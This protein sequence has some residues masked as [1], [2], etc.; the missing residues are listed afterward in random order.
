VVGLIAAFPKALVLAVAG[1]ALLGTIG[2][3]MGVAMKD[4]KSASRRSSPSSSPPAGWRCGAWARRSGAWWRG[5]WRSAV[6]R[7]RAA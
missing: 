4:E 2:S 6:Q 1:F 7:L 3:G 5:R